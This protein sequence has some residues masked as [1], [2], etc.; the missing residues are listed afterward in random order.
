MSDSG[1]DKKDD[2]LTAGYWG[3]DLTSYGDYGHSTISDAVKPASAPEQ[4]AIAPPKRPSRGCTCGQDSM[5]REED[6]AANFHSRW[7]PVHRGDR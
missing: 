4:P 3:W 7:C 6:R 2:S 5:D 1:Q